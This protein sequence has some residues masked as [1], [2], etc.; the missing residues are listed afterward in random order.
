VRSEG[1][2]ARSERSRCVYGRT[3]AEEEWP[4]GPGWPRVELVK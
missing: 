1:A 2:G 4:S 3:G